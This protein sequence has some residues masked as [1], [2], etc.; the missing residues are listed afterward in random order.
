[1]H[2]KA[3]ML[4]CLRRHKYVFIDCCRHSGLPTFRKTYKIW[5]FDFLGGKGCL[6]KKTWV[7][8]LP[9]LKM[10]IKKFGKS[11][12]TPTNLQEHTELRAP[13]NN[14]GRVKKNVYIYYIYIYIY[15]IK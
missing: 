4:K 3:Y 5:E 14:W 7:R 11:F 2:W 15:E 1:M 8:P 6:Q 12:A 9:F 13:A 10:I